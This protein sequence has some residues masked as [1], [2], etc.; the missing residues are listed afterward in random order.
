[1]LESLGFR[2]EEKT[3]SAPKWVAPDTFVNMDE[4]RAEMQAVLDK[5]RKP[6][7]PTCPVKVGNKFTVKTL[8]ERHF[9]RGYQ[10]P[11][12]HEHTVVATRL[13]EPNS[14][15]SRNLEGFSGWTISF[16][17]EMA[18]TKRRLWLPLSCIKVK[19]DA[20]F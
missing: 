18:F 11:M 2:Y 1:M 7:A 14:E 8:P 20:G 6:E 16:D 12:A 9:L 3:Y 5:F 15:A 4:A 19:P 13:I 10:M 17:V